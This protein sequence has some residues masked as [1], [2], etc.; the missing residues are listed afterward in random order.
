VEGQA[1]RD[2]ADDFARHR[3]VILG[4]SF[5]T[6]AENH[7][8]AADQEFPFRLLSDPDRAVGEAYGVARPA[9]DPYA[10]YP[11][12]WSF[13]IDPAGV[14]RSVYDVTDVA[15]HSPCSPTPGAGC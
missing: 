12:R 13:L 3:A 11:R 7:E 15:T 6:V 9:D 10:G 14:V 1:L 5:D 2:S 4:A 8:F